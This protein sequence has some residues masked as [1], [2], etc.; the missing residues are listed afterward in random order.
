MTEIL[1]LTGSIAS[2]KT[3]IS[4]YFKSLGIEVIDADR[5]AHDLMKAGQPIVL[6]IAELFGED[7]LHPTGEINRKRL[8]DIVFQSDKEREKLNKLVQKKIREE[9]EENKNTLLEKEKELIVMD[10]PLLYEESYEDMVDDVMVIYVDSE[11]QI[12]RLMNRDNNLSK[13]DALNRIA[14]QMPL[15]E[16]AEKADVVINN[17]GTLK[18]TIDQVNK[19]LR[20][21]YGFIIEEERDNHM[22]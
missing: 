1:G 16:K 15:E 9:I 12:N 6:K 21:N 13:K 7:I 22:L 18:E 14:S 11:T 8:G 20:K 5:I 4:N 17:N 3:T 10:I 19:W 2:G